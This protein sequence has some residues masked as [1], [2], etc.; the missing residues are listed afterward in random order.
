M[1][2]VFFGIFLVAC[3]G[4]GATGGLFPPGA[5]YRGLTKPSWTPPDW[6][7]P[8]TWSLL[9]LCMSYAAARVAVQPSL[10]ATLALALWGAQIAYNGLWTPVFFGLKRIKA[11][12]L[13]LVGLWVLVALTTIALWRVDWVS[14]VLFLPYLTWVTI[15]GTLNWGVWTRNL[16]DANNPA[17]SET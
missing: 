7:F 1:I 2:W 6:V 4:A 11:G 17:P 3:I 14:G 13:V 5:W 8:V 16:E 12:M 9:Y 15:A 10:E